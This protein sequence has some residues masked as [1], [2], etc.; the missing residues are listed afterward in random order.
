MEAIKVTRQNLSYV[1]EYVVNNAPWAA[2]LVNIMYSNLANNGE[3]TYVYTIDRGAGESTKTFY[4][5]MSEKKFHTIFK[6]V[7]GECTYLV[8]PITKK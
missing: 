5:T 6:F 2:D 3:W 8:M 1:Q 4:Y 7:S